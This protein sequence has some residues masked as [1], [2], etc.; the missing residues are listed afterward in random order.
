MRKLKYFYLVF[1]IAFSIPLV[2]WGFSFHK[3]LE[4]K[5]IA[6]TGTEVEATVVNYYSNVEING[7]P[8]YCLEFKFYD[9]NGNEHFGKTEASYTLYKAQSIDK[10]LIKYDKNFKAVEADFHYT[11]QIELWLLP[12]FGV[13][14]IVFWVIFVKSIFSQSQERK[15]RTQG[16]EKEG[17]FIDYG[18][19]LKINEQPYYFI[20]YQYE[21]DNGEIKQAKT[22]CKYTEE[23]MNYFK[24]FPHFKIKVLNGNSTITEIIDISKLYRNIKSKKEESSLEYRPVFKKCVY[25]E[26]VVSAQDKKCPNCGS[27]KFE[28]IKK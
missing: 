26:S 2:I 18:S 9:T 4:K 16:V 27:A 20:K 19:Y 13:V 15:I 6:K 10:I 3:F 7:E 21:D 24:V 8:Y 12:I 25:C 11:N 1:A 17:L 28:E 22:P 5:H 23:E 14:G